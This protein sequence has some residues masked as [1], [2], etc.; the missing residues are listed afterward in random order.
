MNNKLQYLKEFPLSMTVCKGLYKFKFNRYAC[1]KKYKDKHILD[2]LGSQYDVSHLKTNESNSHNFQKRIWTMWN[3]GMEEAPDIVKMCY[4]SMQKYKP[5]DAELIVITDDNYQEYVSIPDYI[6]E[7]YKKGIITRTHFS[8]ILRVELLR[9]YGGL[10]LDATV[11]VTQPI[12]WGIIDTPFYSISGHGLDLLPF[13]EN[14]WAL[15]TLGSYSNSIVLESLHEL[16]F[17]YW[18]DH[19]QMIDYYLIDYCLGVA[20]RQNT[21]VRQYIDSNPINNI[22]VFE[23]SSILEKDCKDGKL[24]SVL[25]YENPFYKLTYK[26]E[27]NKQL[28]NQ[29]RNEVLG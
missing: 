21:E 3:Q 24:E 28:L 13:S 4:K 10:W 18:K 22:H 29:L 5:E 12:E 15:F 14:K 23:L 9:K 11:L 7:K 1:V 8:D 20:A 27:Y 19:S 16:L 25:S 6:I 26:R 2:Y 17:S